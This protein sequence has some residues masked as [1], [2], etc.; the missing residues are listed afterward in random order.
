MALVNPGRERLRLQVSYSERLVPSG[1][2]AGRPALPFSMSSC[3][4]Q[5]SVRWLFNPFSRFPNHRWP[6]SG[7]ASWVGLSC[8]SYG[9]LCLPS[10]IRVTAASSL[11][12]L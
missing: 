2:R 4:L 11:C 10:A 8:E 3:I 5:L 12:Q 9:V 1:V 7:E 6:L